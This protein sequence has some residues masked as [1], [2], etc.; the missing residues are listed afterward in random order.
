MTKDEIVVG[1]TYYGP[2]DQRLT[3]MAIEGETVRVI[4]PI[5][6]RRETRS[7]DEM[8]EF[9]GGSLIRSYQHANGERR[10]KIKET[11]DAV[12]FY[13]TAPGGPLE[14]VPRKQWAKWRKGAVEPGQFPT[15]RP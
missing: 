5:S 9:I 2:G 4:S 10:V 13:E 14:T 6:L 15:S 8:I 1:R 12:T 7:T 3:V 11:D